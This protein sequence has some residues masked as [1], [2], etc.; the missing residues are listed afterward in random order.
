[1]TQIRSGGEN[2]FFLNVQVSV[3]LFPLT[4]KASPNWTGVQVSD[5][6][7]WKYFCIKELCVRV[8]DNHRKNLQASNCAKEYQLNWG[9]SRQVKDKS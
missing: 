1:M 3:F 2:Y 6:K 4:V 8:K 5:C 7:L 9:K